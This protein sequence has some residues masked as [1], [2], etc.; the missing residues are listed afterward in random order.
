L[1]FQQDD[2]DKGTGRRETGTNFQQML[3]IVEQYLACPFYGRRRVTAWL[4]QHGDA[5][6]G[7]RVQCG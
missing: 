7:K 5:V 4:V 3:Q 2:A 6:N 1:Q